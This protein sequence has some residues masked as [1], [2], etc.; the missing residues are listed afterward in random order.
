[1][2]DILVG[3]QKICVHLHVL[4]LLLEYSSSSY[5]RPQK[6]TS[7]MVSQKGFALFGGQSGTKAFGVTS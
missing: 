7:K 6:V 3:F 4:R 2:Q 1:M 5:E